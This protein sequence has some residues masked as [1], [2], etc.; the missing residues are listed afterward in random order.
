MSVLDISNLEALI[1]TGGIYRPAS[2]S[3]EPRIKLTRWKAFRQKDQQTM[4]FAGD[5][6]GL[7]SR[8]SSAIK[9][10]ISQN[11]YVTNSGRVYEL[12]GP[13]DGISFDAAYVLGFY[14]RKYG[15]AYEDIVD[16]SEDLLEM[17]ISK[18][19][20]DNGD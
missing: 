17:H 6:P 8:V 2:A 7:D 12:V 18:T 13:P 4:F 15:L 20:P 11:E 1:V 9:G 10:R 19:K 14:L 3:K 5:I 16:A